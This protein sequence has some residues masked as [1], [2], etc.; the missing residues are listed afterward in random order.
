MNLDPWSLVTGTGFA[1]AAIPAM[2]F[3]VNLLSYRPPS[4]TCR[5]TR[6]A[7]PVSVLIPARNEAGTIDSAIESVL[8]TAPMAAELEVLVLDDH[9][10]DGTAERVLAIAARDS[11]V[12]LLRGDSLPAGW[13]GKQHACWQLAQAARHPYLIFMDADVRL[14]PD[15]PARLAGFLEARPEVH[16]ASGIPRQTTGT[17][18]EHLLIPLIHV[19]LL[20]YLPLAAARR[21]RWPAF[22]AGC[23]QLFVVRREAYFQA[24]GHRAIRSTLHDGL[25]LPRL[26]RA[27]GFGTDL[28]DATDVASCRMYRGGA[29]VWRGLGKNATEGLAQPTAIVPWTVLLLGGHVLPFI[30]LALVP[31]LPAT[32]LAP[33]LAAAALGW[34]LRVVAAR[35]FRQNLLGAILHPVGIALLVLIQW[36]ALLR[37]WRGRPSEWRGRR[38]STSSDFAAPTPTS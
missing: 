33:S 13:C 20:G 31:W 10:T 7:L 14:E 3:A 22:A 1:L 2:L 21:I 11:R 29:E 4:R 12:Q 34:G 37:R 35:V 16:L 8:A 18:L 19:I 23:G 25:K 6:K 36:V 5:G 17:F 27:A 26:M 38:Y 28:F 9:S 30:L 32:A 15:A 24:G